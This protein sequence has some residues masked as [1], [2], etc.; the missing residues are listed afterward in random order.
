MKIV[1]I[2]LIVL[3]SVVGA[4]AASYYVSPS[5]SDSAAGTSSA[6]WLTFS[7]AWT[8][9]K[10]GDSLIAKDGTYSGT[11]N[12]FTNMPSGSAGNY[13]V[14]KAEHDGMVIIT[15]D[16]A[17]SHTTSYLQFEGLRFHSQNKFALGNHLRFM[18]CEFKNGC[19][20]GNCANMGA[21]T[22]DYDDTS[23]ILFEDCWVHGPG[24][25]YNMIIYNTNRV[26]MRRVVVRHDGG[27]TDDKGDPE[28]GFSIYNSQ[29]IALDNVIVID[30]N[31]AYHTWS[32]ATYTIYNSASPGATRN[33][34]WLGSIVLNTAA[35]CYGHDCAGSGTISNITYDNIICYGTMDGGMAGGSQ[36]S[37]SFKVNHATFGGDLPGGEYNGG[38]GKWNSGTGTVKNSIVYGFTGP[39]FYGVSASYTDSYNNGDQ[40]SCSNCKSINPVT[41]GLKY[42]P[43]IEAGSTLS[44]GGESAGRMGAEILKRYGAS[45]TMQGEAGYNTLTTDNL[46]PWPYEERIKKEMCTDPG[47]TR[48]FCSSQSLTKYIWEYLGNACPADICTAGNSTP[49][50]GDSSCNANENCSTCAS[51]CGSCP[52]VCGDHV[53]NGNENCTTCSSDC[54]I[55]TA[56]CSDQS[57]NGN[58]NCTTCPTDCGQ[59]PVQCLPAEIAPCN[60]CIDAA[61]LS[62][63]IAQW[64]ASTVIT[65]KQ[66]IDAIA[67]WKGGC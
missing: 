2:A 54:G 1:V 67:L 10:A 13:I 21:G 66:L 18:R 12:S 53:C 58:E 24:G 36:G 20:S 51:D 30:S 62:T 3:L 34:D 23:D 7:K 11:T 43:R 16:L 49:Y 27:W 56:V 60:G 59:C 9:V 28:A 29:N 5:G 57:C 31:L 38:F 6:P 64:K 47:V 48:G 45:G 22:N 8:V 39:D 33:V 55:C 37:I 17:P 19:P 42:L 15:S 4:Q 40:G 41:N 25:R 63:Y 50:C 61:E 44:S 35:H 14:V 46:W 65:M 52:A 26:V 32:Q